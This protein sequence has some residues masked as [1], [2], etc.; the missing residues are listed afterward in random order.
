[1]KTNIKKRTQHKHSPMTGSCVQSKNIYSETPAGSSFILVFI[2]G[3]FQMI[4]SYVWVC[5]YL[6]MCVHVCLHVCMC[7]CTRVW[8]HVCFL[9]AIC[10]HHD[11]QGSL[12]TRNSLG[13]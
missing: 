10:R 4:L 11:M 1:M 12:Q 3:D 8:A 2:L 5:A 9:I 13:P 6:C 7:V